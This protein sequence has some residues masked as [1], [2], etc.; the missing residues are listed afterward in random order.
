[1]IGVPGLLQKQ[2]KGTGDRDTRQGMG[3]GTED[4]DWKGAGDGAESRAE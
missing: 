3:L 2:R 4:G 1:M